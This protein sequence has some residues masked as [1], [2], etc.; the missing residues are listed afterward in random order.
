MGFLIVG[1]VHIVEFGTFTFLFFIKRKCY[2]RGKQPSNSILFI[3]NLGVPYDLMDDGNCVEDKLGNIEVMIEE[4]KIAG[5]DCGTGAELVVGDE[6][7]VKEP[8]PK[9]LNGEEELRF[10]HGWRE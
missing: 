10:S 7:I 6:V 9:K 8:S 5:S 4:K 3:Q 1:V 2:D